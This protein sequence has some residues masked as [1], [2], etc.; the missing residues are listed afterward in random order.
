[1]T[2]QHQSLLTLVYQLIQRII[3]KTVGSP[4]YM[5]PESICRIIETKSDL[6]AVDVILFVLL[7]GEN[8]F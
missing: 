4:N 8:A 3:Q 2:Y 6:W 1:M 7:T 5:S